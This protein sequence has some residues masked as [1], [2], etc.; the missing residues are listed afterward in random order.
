MPF[1]LVGNLMIMLSGLQQERQ[2]VLPERL[3]IGYAS[4]SFYGPPV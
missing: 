4:D 2:P 3:A 1:L